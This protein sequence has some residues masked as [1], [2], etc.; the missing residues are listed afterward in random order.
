[1]FGYNIP[2]IF[3]IYKAGL[4]ESARQLELSHL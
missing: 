1:M 3:V 4:V 2:F